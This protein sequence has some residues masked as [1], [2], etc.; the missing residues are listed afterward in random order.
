MIARECSALVADT[1]LSGSRAARELDHVIALRGKPHT[2][3]SNNE[4]MLTSSAILRWS[5]ERRVEWH[6]IASGKP[7][8]NGLAESSNGRLRNECL[9][10]TLFTSLPHASSVLMA[11]EEG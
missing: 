4:T 11:W 8:Q 2:V 1:S 7:M 10:E 5:Q 6:Y 3:V 9:S